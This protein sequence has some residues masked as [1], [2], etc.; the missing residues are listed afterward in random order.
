MKPTD[1]TAETGS[2]KVFVC[3]AKH[4]GFGMSRYAATGRKVVVAKE[5]GVF[6]YTNIKEDARTP[7]PKVENGKTHMQ[8]DQ[9]ST[10]TI[11]HSR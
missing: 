3:E 6:G 5:T 10:T 2:T 4:A 8:Q 11:R 1:L 9:K 7:P